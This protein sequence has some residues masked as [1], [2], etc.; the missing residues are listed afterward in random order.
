MCSE[1]DIQR[2][3]S[4]KYVVVLKW[5]HYLK[6]W[7]P[8]TALLT[9]LIGAT[10][11]KTSIEQKVFDDVEQ[12]QEVLYFVSRGRA[13]TDIEKANIINHMENEDVHMTTK[14][15]IKFFVPRVELESQLESL[16]YKLDLILKK[17]D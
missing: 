10:V 17:D 16:N 7:T 12:K 4:G 11:W 14:D 5:E 8:I 15:K 1:K 2:I 9:L 13:L 3:D 6:L